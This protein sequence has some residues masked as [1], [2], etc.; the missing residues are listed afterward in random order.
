MNP[1]DVIIQDMCN[2]PLKWNIDEYTLC[3]DNINIWISNGPLSYN[4]WKCDLSCYRFTIKDRIKF[5][6]AHKKWGK[7]KA[8]KL[9]QDLMIKNSPLHKTLSKDVE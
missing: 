9:T 6:F 7:L 1:V 3:N 5:Y 8:Y 4:F 2:N